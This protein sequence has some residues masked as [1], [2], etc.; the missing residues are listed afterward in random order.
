MKH[1]ARLVDD[2][3][4]NEDAEDFSKSLSH[5]Y[6]ASALSNR[7]QLLNLSANFGRKIEAIVGIDDD[8]NNIVQSCSERFA[9]LK[10]CIVS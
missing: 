7:D 9:S 1:I 5:S 10:S 3:K 4:I 6:F 8:L 2:I